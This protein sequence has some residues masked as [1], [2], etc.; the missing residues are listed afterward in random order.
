M[1]ISL[2]HALENVHVES[3]VVEWE[4][5]HAE[6]C[7]AGERNENVLKLY[8]ETMDASMSRSEN[9]NMTLLN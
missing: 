7:L 2:K 1:K 3:R 8:K 9:K 5:T 6:N 4:V